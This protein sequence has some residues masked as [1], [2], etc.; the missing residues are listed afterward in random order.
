MSDGDILAFIDNDERID[1]RMND[2]IRKFLSFE[3]EKINILNQL[4][5]EREKILNS[6]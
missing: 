3:I 5:L 1:Q 6:Y 2:I 4:D